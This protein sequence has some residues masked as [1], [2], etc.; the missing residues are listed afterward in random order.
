M[1][2]VKTAK[3]LSLIALMLVLCMLATLY[4]LSLASK[5]M[6]EAEQARIE[7]EIAEAEQLAAE[8]AAAAEAEAAE[9]AA[10]V[11]ERVYSYR[12]SSN[13]ELYT[14]AAYENAVEA[15]SGFIAFP[16]VVSGDGTLYVAD[17]D[18]AHSLTGYS[19]FFSGMTDGQ[20]AELT[21][22]GGASLVKVSDLFDK[23]GKEVNYIIE[24]KYTGNR[25]I[26]ALK[27]LLKNY[28]LSDNIAIS[29]TYFNG[30][31]SIEA[32]L[33]DIPKIFICSN[34]SDFNEALSMSEIDTISVSR[35]MMSE[36]YCKSA[37]G[38]GKK[39]GAWTLNSEED[40]KSAIGMGADSYFTD[41]TAVA[42]S[43]EKAE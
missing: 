21:T 20:I 19:G 31:R 39:C 36:D 25:N 1:K 18:Q 26:E 33:P 27:D 32:D 2:K 28:D 41:E 35:D 40:I 14:M 15:G 11:P 5:R 43:A 29:S 23:F 6:E 34:E 24:L 12:G 37:H 30:L 22:R 42:V 38:C 16:F 10:S 9:K 17:D 4:I 13:D 7:Q 3:R 8:E